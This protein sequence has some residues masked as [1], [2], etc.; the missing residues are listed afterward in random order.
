MSYEPIENYGVI[1]DLHTDALV[2]MNG[3]IDFMCF[4]RF[5]SPTIFA[6]LLDDEKGGRFSLA[7]EFNHSVHKQIYLP[8]SCILLSRFLSSEGVA[9]VSDFMPLGQSEVQHDLVR[10]AKT[11]HGEVRFRMLCQPRFDYARCPHKIEAK[12]ERE[13]LFLPEH[14][15]KLKPV[16]LLSSVPMKIENG[17]AVAEFTLKTGQSATF[18]LAEV[19][20]QGQQATAPDFAPSSFKDTLN[21]WRRW[22]GR[23]NYRGRWREMVQRSAMTLKLLTSQPDGSIVAAPTFG[24]PESIGGILNW[25]YRYTWIRDASLSVYSLLKLGFT[26]EADAYM[27]WLDARCC[28][29]KEGERLQAMYALDGH[30]SLEEFELPHLSGYRDSRPVRI[31]NAAHDQVQLDIYGQLID[32]AYTYNELGSP[33]SFDLWKNLV[34]M[35]NWVCEHWR[36][37]GAGLWEFRNATREFTNAR[38]MCWKALDRGLGLANR[39][40]FPA[41]VDRWRAVRDEI[42]EDVHARFWSEELH[43]FVRHKGAK[44]VDAADLHLLLSGFLGPTDRRWLATLKAIQ[45][46]LVTDSLVFRYEYPL[47]EFR[48][49][50]EGTF[51]I[52][53]F[54]YIEALCRSGDADLARLLFEK[55]L[56]YANHLGL[57]AEELGPCGEHLG[58]FPQAFSHLGLISA[59]LELEDRL[60]KCHRD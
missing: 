10:R 49:E 5:D 23:C 52:C 43:T 50:T 6:A 9:E 17:N 44:S 15:G 2:G 41:P 29:M 53:S 35:V 39:C 33:I 24:L 58:N 57:Y 48:R 56:G 40:A 12:G 22:I 27:R 30:H 46:R 13:I 31:G 4:P 26:E 34:P 11:V 8:E 7:P 37:E 16:R 20:P 3:S 42:Y 38:V 54:W 25:D 59:A 32:C 14:N 36:D 60:N 55:L 51:C 1:G 28:E 47:G 21:F 19:S 45:E 18:I